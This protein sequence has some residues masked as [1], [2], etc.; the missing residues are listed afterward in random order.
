MMGLKTT[1]QCVATAKDLLVSARS[2]KSQWEYAAWWDQRV[3]LFWII[4]GAL[5][6]GR[7]TGEAY[8]ELW[9][10]KHTLNEAESIAG[11]Y[12]ND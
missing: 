3:E 2:I 4:Q 11:R 8:D 10:A 1:S 9:Q 5:E 6:S 7:F 12:A